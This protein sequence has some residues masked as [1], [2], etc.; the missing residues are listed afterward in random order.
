MALHVSRSKEVL[1]RSRSVEQDIPILVSTTSFDANR[2]WSHK[3]VKTIMLVESQTHKEVASWICPSLAKSA[4]M[5]RKAH[6]G[7]EAVKLNVI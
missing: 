2:I 5:E 6:H 4:D 7:V 3:R 1:L